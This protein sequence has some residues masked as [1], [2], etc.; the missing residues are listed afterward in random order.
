MIPILLRT[1]WVVY[2]TPVRSI[3]S[4]VFARQ[5]QYYGGITNKW[6]LRLSDYT[7][8]QR[9]F[10]SSAKRPFKCRKHECERSFET[11]EGLN[12]HLRSLVHLPRTLPCIEE[13][14]HF[15]NYKL[16]SGMAHHLERPVETGLKNVAR[17]VSE[18][19]EQNVVTN[20]EV[21]GAD[22]VTPPLG[23]LATEDTWSEEKN[24]YVCPISDCKSTFPKLDRLRRHLDSQVHRTDKKTYKCSSCSAHFSVISAALQHMEKGCGDITH[25]KV[26]GKY[27][28]ISEALRSIWYN[29]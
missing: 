27:N 7:P 17:V 22:S 19:D 2:S 13:R 21:A 25:E 5:S 24:A 10:V 15:Q 9:R 18:W 26:K 23:Y 8:L 12:S 29:R 14:P 1:T 28:E 16:P 4:P 3:S 11:E 20:P 6:S